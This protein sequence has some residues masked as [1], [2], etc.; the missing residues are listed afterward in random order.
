MAAENSGLV[1]PLDIGFGSKGGPKYSTSIV[2]V[3]SGTE[4]RNINWTYP[5]HQYDVSYGV[6]TETQMETLI[7]FFHL[8]YGSAIAFL[9]FDYLDHAADRASSGV[10]LAT[11]DAEVFQL[12][13]KYTV[14]ASSKT[15]KITRPKSPIAVYVGGV[16]SETAAVDYG[17]GLVTFDGAPGGAVTWTGEFYVPARFASDELQLDPINK[18]T[19]GDLIVSTQILLSEI[20][21]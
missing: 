10:T 7:G 12:A 9:Y 20:R 11:D 3:R 21:E 5:L 17:T 4:K 13:R 6:K 14:G 1:F 19:D 8:H 18:S 16:L 2:A 15:R